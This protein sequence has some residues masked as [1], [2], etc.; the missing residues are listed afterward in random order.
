MTNPPYIRIQ[1]LDERTRKNISSNFL[2]CKGDTDIYVAFFEKIIRSEVIAGFICPNSWRKNKFGK[3]LRSLVRDSGRIDSIIDFKSKKVFDGVGTYTSILVVDNKKTT[4]AQAGNNLESLSDLSTSDL[5]VEDT[6]LI[7]R[8]ERDFVSEVLSRE[9][10]ILDFCDIKVGLATLCDSVFLLELVSTQ[11]RDDKGVKVSLVKERK[12]NSIPFMIEDS[13]L[14]KCHKAGE[15]TK[16]PNKKYVIIYPYD[17]KGKT[18]SEDSFSQNYPIAYDYLLSNKEK[19]LKRDK[20]KSKNY[21]WY[22]YGRT[23][24]L[25]L[26]EKSKLVFPTMIKDKMYLRESKQG[27]VFI[28][29]YCVIPKKLITNADIENI[30]LSSDMLKWIRVFGK[31]MGAEW[32]GIS[33]ETFVKYRINPAHVLQK[34]S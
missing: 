16:N 24:A 2:C 8:S 14:V 4:T 27:E 6:L 31:S 20:G 7:D 28:S 11:H 10:S 33:K 15:I 22:A 18:I 19:L 34:T 23:Q 17:K 32:L 26:I 3:A 25:S 30:F 21:A 9:K 13:I 1:N 29:G 12:K 5:F